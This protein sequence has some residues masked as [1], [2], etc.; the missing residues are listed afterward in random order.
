M[1]DGVLFR[2]NYKNV[3]LRFL[4]NDD[5]NHILSELHDVLVGGNFGGETTTHKVL[6][7]GY[8][9]PTL[10]RDTHAYARKC[11]ICQVN[12]GRER[13]PA[14]LLQPIIVQNPFEQWGLDVVDEID[15]NSS[16]LY[17]YILT[18]TDY[19]SKWTKAVPLKVIN[20]NEVI[21]FLQPNIVTRFGVPDCLV[22]YN[23]TYFMSLKIVEFELKYNITLKYS[24]NYYLQGN[25][26][27]DSTNKN[28]LRIIKK[29]VA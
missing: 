25:G 14:F 1:I 19:F 10:F 18:T 7:E 27:V 17:K 2:Q 23:A 8:Y 24:T 6:R 9:W 28:L 26:V 20:D 16:K 13:R 22:F 21:Q 11:Q 4:E 15:P 29:T 5:V 12:V 3:L